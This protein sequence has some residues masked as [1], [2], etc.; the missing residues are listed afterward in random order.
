MRKPVFVTIG[1]LLA[2]MGLVFM[3]QGFGLIGGSAMTGSAV[4]AVVGPIIALVGIALIVVG[5]RGGPTSRE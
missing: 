4:W 2:V 5:L 3:F 1:A